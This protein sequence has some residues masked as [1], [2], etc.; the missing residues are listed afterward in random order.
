M[1]YS[2]SKSIPKRIKVSKS[3]GALG[4]NTAKPPQY[5]NANEAILIQNYL[6]QRE[7]DVQRRN[8]TV[9][10]VET[11]GLPPKMEQIWTDT[12]TMIGYGTTL[13]VWNRN[14]NT[15]HTV[16][17]N[18]TKNITDGV[19]YGNDFY[20]CNGIF[21]DKIYKTTLPSLDFDAQ[22]ANFTNG[23]VITGGTSG[24]TATIISQTDV[25]ATGTL[26]LDNI[27]GTFVDNEIITD[28]STGSATVNGTMSW[29]NTA[30]ISASSGT[31]PK[32]EFLFIFGTRLVAGKTDAATYRIHLSKEA[33]FTNWNTTTTLV[34]DSY[35][36]DFGRA[37]AVTGIATITGTNNTSSQ[38]A[39]IL[40][41]F[42]ENGRL[43]WHQETTQL[44][45]DTIQTFPNDI[46]VL[47][48]GGNGRPYSTPM[49]IFFG[50]ENGEFF[51]R[52]D[53]Q[54]INLSRNFGRNKVV[55]FDQ[56]DSDRVWLPDREIVLV[57]T[58]LQSASNN[59]VFW[60]NTRSL[61][62]NAPIEEINVKWGEITGVN[63][64][65][66][67]LQNAKL[68]ITSSSSPK[69]SEMFAENVW[70]DDGAD[71]YYRYV[72]PL[73]VGVTDKIRDMLEFYIEGFLTAGNPVTVDIY[74]YDEYGSYIQTPVTYTW[75]T[76]STTGTL[77]EWSE[78]EWGDGF[79]L[80]SSP[81][82]TAWT[83]AKGYKKAYG[84]VTYV[85]DI[86]GNDKAPNVLSYISTKTAEV[87][88]VRQS[89]LT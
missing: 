22:T 46:E 52:N 19:R 59:Q 2:I 11:T 85:V 78:S 58:R 50:N 49:G 83:P 40:V 68:Y 79:G 12:L 60:I 7:A 56:T 25:G 73:N 48:A 75:S 26:V 69:V 80:S 29:T 82:G 47:D 17:S 70:D 41:S 5:L 44:G 32:C 15:L 51:M 77:Q 39:D 4:Q 24:A 66:F 55:L 33:D 13:A 37:G 34:G 9:K 74:A 6:V 36:K 67:S 23:L 72:Q 10:K 62:Q 8:G 43:G 53:R 87:R 45:T 89:L 71:I 42:F 88:D 76:T 63:V 28:S 14:D 35:Y 54:I 30:E 61:Q 84:Y 27:T 65:R 81:S 20:S 31:V 1:P 21:G 57:S 3:T 38:Y 16:K 18:F 64:G 86:H